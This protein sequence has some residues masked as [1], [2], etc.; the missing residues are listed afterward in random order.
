MNETRGGRDAPDEEAVG[1]LD[2]LLVLVLG[3]DL[4]LLDLL[5]HGLG[6]DVD[7]V[8]LEGRHRVVAASKR[9]A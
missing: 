4:L 9:G 5:D 3:D 8:L 7:L 6:L 2:E 1:V